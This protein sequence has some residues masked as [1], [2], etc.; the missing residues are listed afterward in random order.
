[1]CSSHLPRDGY[2]VS[3]SVKV[4]GIFHPLMTAHYTRVRSHGVLPC[5]DETVSQFL[6]GI[7]FNFFYL[8]TGP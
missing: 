4:H 1:M 2:R 3:W 5:E 7:E 6:V 8:R